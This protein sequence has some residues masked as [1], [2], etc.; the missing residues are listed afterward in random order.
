[1]SENKNKTLFIGLAAAGIVLGASALYYYMKN[2]TELP[3]EDVDRIKEL[4][5]NDVK[6]GDK[7]QLDA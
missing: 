6:M 5:L 3:K 4:G 2:G 7:N 1:M